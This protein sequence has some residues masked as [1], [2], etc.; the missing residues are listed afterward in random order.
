MGMFREVTEGKFDSFDE[1]SNKMSR[2]VNKPG[3]SAIKGN[4]KVEPTVELLS[5]AG[6]TQV[7]KDFAASNKNFRETLNAQAP[8]SQEKVLDQCNM[9]SD[10]DVDYLEKLYGRRLDGLRVMSVFS[11]VSDNPVKAMAELNNMILDAQKPA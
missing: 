10:A 2:E 11:N 4:D 1:S 8:A 9:I 7:S 3:E 6:S 5:D